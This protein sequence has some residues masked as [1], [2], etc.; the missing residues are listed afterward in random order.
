M[1]F[2]KYLGCSPAAAGERIRPGGHSLLLLPTQEELSL[3]LQSCASTTLHGAQIWVSVLE[4]QPHP[5][6]SSLSRWLLCATYPGPWWKLHIVH[7]SA[8]K[9]GAY[10]GLEVFSLQEEG[11]RGWLYWLYFRENICAHL[12]PAWNFPAE[13]LSEEDPVTAHCL[14]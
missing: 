3:L 5:R 1:T 9:G 14:S 6:G 11:G 7:C 8:L 12:D 10:S 13:P 2:R 4:K